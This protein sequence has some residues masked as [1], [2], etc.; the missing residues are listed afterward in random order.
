MTQHVV[1]VGCGI[2]GTSGA[3]SGVVLHPFD[4]GGFGSPA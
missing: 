2:V 1:M 4:P 3:N